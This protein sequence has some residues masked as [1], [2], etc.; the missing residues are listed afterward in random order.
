MMF[1]TIGHGRSLEEGRITREDLDCYLALLRDT[2]TARNELAMGRALFSRT[3]ALHDGIRL[4]DAVL[5]SIRAPTY[6]LWGENDPFGGAETARGLVD[7]IAG[8]EL[9][10]MV[11]G[12]HAPW[13]DDLDRAAL[14]V[15]RFLGRDDGPR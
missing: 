12:G 15:R 3:G 9:E 2:D 10:L 4:A 14:T 6:F 7:R 5:D 11:G 8:A 13:L 1:R